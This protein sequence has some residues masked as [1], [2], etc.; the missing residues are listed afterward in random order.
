LAHF[1]DVE[2]LLQ[3]HSSYNALLPDWDLYRKAYKGGKDF[4]SLALIKQPRES[5][6][7]YEMRLQEVCNFNYCQTIVNVFHQFISE[8]QPDIDWGKKLE[9]E[10]QFKWFLEDANLRGDSFLTFFDDIEKLSSV[11]G[12]MGILVNKAKSDGIKGSE[13]SNNIYPYLVPFNPVEIYDYDIEHDYVTGKDILNYVKLRLSKKNGKEQILYYTK[14]DWEIYEIVSTPGSANSGPELILKDSGENRL[15]RVPFEFH[16]NMKDVDDTYGGISDISEIAIIN[17]SIVRNWSSIEE[18][19]KNAAFP[20]L[21]MPMQSN[22]GYYETTE[23][24]DTIDGTVNPDSP[25]EVVVS[26]KSVI[27]FDPTYGEN[28]KPDWLESKVKEPIEAILTVIEKKTEEAYRV[29]H[30]SNLY[31]SKARTQYIKSGTAMEY[32]FKLLK[33]V[34]S[35]KV[36][37][38]ASVKR[39]IIRLWLEWQ[40]LSHLYKDVKVG[41]S[42]DFN[43]YKLIDN[44][45]TAMGFIN[46]THS[47]TVRK[48]FY[49]SI[50]PIFFPT[51]TEETLKEI[52]DEISSEANNLG[53]AEN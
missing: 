40:N 30:L 32:D 34:L 9:D 18:I 21:R 24:T 43:L 44:L 48:V 37:N 10:T 28:G 11:Y 46:G 12:Y 5:D 39:K 19:I 23:N 51:I 45:D 8:K 29:K 6:D 42:K 3:K 17:G 16:I 27:E 22:D 14:D 47:K 7:N 25:E 13:I 1:T 4:I 41:V 26:S 52:E 38:N 15:G 49:R 35:R 33:T 20:M 53:N 36:D 2:K 50:M 31:S